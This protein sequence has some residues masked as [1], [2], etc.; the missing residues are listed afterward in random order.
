MKARTQVVLV[1]A[2]AAALLASTSG[3]GAQDRES[4]DDNPILEFDDGYTPISDADLN[5]LIESEIGY[6]IGFRS[7]VNLPHDRPTVE[8]I[9]R[10]PEARATIESFGIPLTQSEQSEMEVRATIGDEISNLHETWLIGED[11]YGGAYLD[12][13]TGQVVINHVKELS[14]RQHDKV[15]KSFSSP[16]RVS[17]RTVEHSFIDL[18]KATATIETLPL[19]RLPKITSTFADT[20]VG[21]VR[22][23]VHDPDADFEELASQLSQAVGGVKVVV[24]YE[25]FA[26]VLACPNRI[27]CATVSTDDF[28]G[29]TMLLSHDFSICT[30]GFIAKDT[31]DREFAITAGHCRVDPAHTNGTVGNQTAGSIGFNGVNTIWDNGGWITASSDTDAALFRISDFRKSNRVY[32]NDS[33]KNWFINKKDNWHTQGQLVCMLGLTSGYR[34]GPVTGS[35]VTAWGNPEEVLVGGG[36]DL[37]KQLRFKLTTEGHDVSFVGSSG[38][39]VIGDENSSLTHRTA[40][41]I[42]TRGLGENI[43]LLGQPFTKTQIYVSRFDQ[44][45]ADL[46][47]D[48]YLST[49]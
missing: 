13:A 33:Y 25:P 17:F 36:M 29:G 22:V 49:P 3:A 26:E 42:V 44:L 35:T 27:T 19:E 15:V 40:V 28:R 37:T 32:K 41:G 2:I 31:A 46:D 16:E 38:G 6:W 7:S 4:L 9:A 21:G 47:V 20:E 1:L 34:C 30:T 45:E 10:L 43:Y 18:E 24:Q 12:H 39:A 14:M 5:R 23:G 8:K 11:W 48:I